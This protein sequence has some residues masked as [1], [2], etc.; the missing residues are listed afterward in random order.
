MHS[1]CIAADTRNESYKEGHFRERGLLSAALNFKGLEKI[2]EKGQQWDQTTNWAAFNHLTEFT[3]VWKF[4][5]QNGLICSQAQL[6]QLAANKGHPES[7]GTWAFSEYTLE[8]TP[9]PWWSCVI[10]SYQLLLSCQNIWVSCFTGNIMQ[11]PQSASLLTQ[12]IPLSK[13][14]F[15]FLS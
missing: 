8:F 7:K 6:S 12:S 4:P 13:G 11:S 15:T 3:V 1:W 9:A 5:P 10:K 14:Q 2:N